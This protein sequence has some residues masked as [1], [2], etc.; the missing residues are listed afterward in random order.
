[1]T[2]HY[3]VLRVRPDAERDTIRRSFRALARECH[4]DFGGDAKQMQTILEAWSVLGRPDRRAAYDRDRG[5]SGTNDQAMGASTRASGRVGMPTTL[6]YGRYRGWTI[7]ALADHD[8]DY[9]EWLRRSPGGRAWRT[10]IDAVL[11]DRTARILVRPAP[12]KRR[13]LWR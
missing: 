2:D 5:S 10:K 13:R 8:P 9:L 7:E 12:A 11:A 4:P 6:D 3:A 1:M